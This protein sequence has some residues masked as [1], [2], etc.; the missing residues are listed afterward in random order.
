MFK[1]F[2]RNGGTFLTNQGAK[3]PINEILLG[4][5]IPSTSLEKIVGDRFLQSYIDGD[6]CGDD[7]NGRSMETIVFYECSI[8]KKT[9]WIMDIVE[10]SRGRY[11]LR[12]GSPEFC[13]WPSDDFNQVK[14]NL[15]LAPLTRCFPVFESKIANP[16]TNIH[17]ENDLDFKD[18]FVMNSDL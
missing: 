2:V 12:V 1:N 11:T 15:L 7:L 8:E 17:A 9:P 14:K 18:N 6:S 4:R 16:F 13:F 5:F 10:T 3:T